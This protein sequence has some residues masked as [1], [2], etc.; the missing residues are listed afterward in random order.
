[1]DNKIE[2]QFDASSV[3][4]NILNFIIP[5]VCIG[6]SLVIGFFV[7]YPY[8]KNAPKVK[9]EIAEKQQLKQVLE[10]KVWILKKNAEFKQVLDEGSALVD[11]VLVSDANVPQLLDEVYQIATNVGLGVTRL[12]YS[13]GGVAVGAET[14][15]AGEEFKEVNVG[16]GG[17]GSYEQLISLLRDTENA[18][19]ILY[20]SDLRYSTGEEG[21]LSMNFTIISP[22]LYV[23]STAATDVPVDL[24]ITNPVFLE[25]VNRLKSLRYYEFLNKD[26][27]I[28]EE[29]K[30]E[31]AEGTE[32]ADAEAAP[33]E[34]VPAETPAE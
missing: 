25:S 11:K 26:I 19:R 20:V 33:E 16:L 15:Q 17:D 34:N 1:M 10:K 28:I 29:E 13:Y 5:L 18:A 6:V 3:K 23:Q 4:E 12:N 22:Y 24:D 8:F 9:I 2:L 7:I 31:D 27:K 21:S 14:T 32:E 30:A